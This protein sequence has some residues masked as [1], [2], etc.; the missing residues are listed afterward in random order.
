MVARPE[1]SRGSPTIINRSAAGADPTGGGDSLVV[2]PHQV[3][4]LVL[5]DRDCQAG[6]GKV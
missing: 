3:K 4:E 5:V 1:D 6:I 2:D